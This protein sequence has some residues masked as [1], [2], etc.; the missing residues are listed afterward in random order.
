MS[1]VDENLIHK[2]LAN[3][4]RRD[5]LRW[6]KTPDQ[7]FTRGCIDLGHGVP[8]NAIQARSG[9]SQSNV[10][11]HVAALVD[12]ELLVATRV[13]QWV[14]LTRNEA[15]IDAFAAQIRLHL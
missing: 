4:F 14:F 11:A 5:V 2:A 7:H 12:A 10:S 8:V 13:G 3:P 1:T 6:L 9:L 15:V